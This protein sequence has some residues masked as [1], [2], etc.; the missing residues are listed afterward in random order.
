M[1]GLL[2][3]FDSSSM[4]PTGRWK[5]CI[6]MPLEVVVEPQDPRFVADGRVRER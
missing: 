3:G 5:G 2:S 1:H 4:T 6:P